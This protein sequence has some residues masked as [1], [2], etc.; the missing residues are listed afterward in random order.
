[1]LGFSLQGKGREFYQTY[2]LEAYIDAYLKMVGS[3]NIP[4][5]YATLP[6][7]AASSSE[8]LLAARRACMRYV[9]LEEFGV[10]FSE[11]PP[12]FWRKL[13]LWRNL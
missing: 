3:G 1:M 8:E 13:W 12:S 4:L 9:L 6:K 7:G 11:T 5:N 2:T 10:L